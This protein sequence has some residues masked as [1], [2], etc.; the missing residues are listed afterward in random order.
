MLIGL[1]WL[2]SGVAKQ[3]QKLQSWW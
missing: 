1:A 3:P 2:T